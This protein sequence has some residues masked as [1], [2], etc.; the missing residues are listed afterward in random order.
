[1]TNT[2]PGAGE[3]PRL[4][5]RP[6]GG[7][8]PGCAECGHPLA[9]HSNGTTPCKAFACTAG[10]DGTPCQEFRAP[11]EAARPQGGPARLAS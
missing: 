8:P 4:G 9:L 5:A 1:M 2:G 3:E 11:E 7:T 6:A 10:P